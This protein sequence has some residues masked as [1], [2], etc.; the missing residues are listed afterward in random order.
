MFITWS[1]SGTT[2][3]LFCPKFLLRQ[4]WAKI[5]SKMSRN[6]EKFEILG[7]N[8]IWLFNDALA[9]KMVI[10]YCTIFQVLNHFET[11]LK[12]FPHFCWFL[13]ETSKEKEVGAG[14]KWFF[15]I[16]FFPVDIM[17]KKW[18]KTFFSSELKATK[19]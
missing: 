13:S 16:N 5:G 10:I 1:K 7:L 18:G 14:V 9:V 8:L 3:F 6:V 2:K 17:L 19:I 11:F 15:E 12:S 4:K